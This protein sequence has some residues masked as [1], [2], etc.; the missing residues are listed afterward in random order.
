M[1]GQPAGAP[2]SA[3][4]SAAA[5]ASGTTLASGVGPGTE[6]SAVDASCARAPAAP[7]LA[8]APPLSDALRIPAL[9]LEIP[10]AAAG[11][12]ALAGGGLDAGWLALAGAWA[13]G[14]QP[15]LTAAKHAAKQI[16]RDTAE[17]PGLNKD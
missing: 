15:P 9:G 10:A 14:V 12:P 1:P 2:L 7:A 17:N 16:P 11:M 3:A 4:A 13:A 6:A 5:P 8:G